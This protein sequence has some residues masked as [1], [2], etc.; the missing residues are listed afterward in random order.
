MIHT[1]ICP[2]C[3]HVDVGIVPD[4]PSSS[5]S[6]LSGIQALVALTIILLMIIGAAVWAY[7]SPIL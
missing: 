1:R 6:E 4:A 2:K 5:S 3:G 7:H